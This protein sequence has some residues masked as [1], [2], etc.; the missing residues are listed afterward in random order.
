MN[1]KISYFSFNLNL[2]FFD[3]TNPQSNL[4]LKNFV[5]NFSDENFRATN[6]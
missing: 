2:I 3:N 4:N 6:I 5:T 1:L